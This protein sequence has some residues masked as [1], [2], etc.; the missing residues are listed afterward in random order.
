MREMTTA[1]TLSGNN[2][3]L[4]FVLA[5]QD[6]PSNS[7]AAL[8]L[9]RT[10]RVCVHDEGEESERASLLLAVGVHAALATGG[11]DGVH[12]S[13]KNGQGDECQKPKR[14]IDKNSKRSDSPQSLRSPAHSRG[15]HLAP[16]QVDASD[17]RSAPGV[18]LGQWPSRLACPL[19]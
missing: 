19:P 18:I 11:G 1:P 6:D 14:R 5:R 12:E 13:K 8:I 10:E 7:G 4:F 17:G 2:R 3:H 15:N 9:S 16:D